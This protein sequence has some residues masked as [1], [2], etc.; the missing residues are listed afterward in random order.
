MTQTGKGQPRQDS[1][2]TGPGDGG[3]VRPRAVIARLLAADVA[4]AYQATH[5]DS[6]P[7]R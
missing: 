3:G 2:R 5:L 6:G 4:F 7:A 1:A